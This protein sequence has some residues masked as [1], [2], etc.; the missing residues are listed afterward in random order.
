MLKQLI[1]A[2]IFTCLVAI[3]C[4][5]AVVGYFAFGL[6]VRESIIV[7]IGALA[8]L[9]CLQV[10]LTLNRRLLDLEDELSQTTRRLD[11][12]NTELDHLT[13]HSDALDEGLRNMMNEGDAALK[14]DVR[15]L[16]GITRKL[17]ERTARVEGAFAHSQEQREK[18]RAALETAAENVRNQTAPQAQSASQPAAIPNPDDGLTIEDLAQS[19]AP[20]DEPQV[21]AA[22]AAEYRKR[23]ELPGTTD[24]ARIVRALNTSIDQNRIDVH[25]QAVMTLPARRADSYEA[26]ARFKADDGTLITAAEALPIARREG[27]MAE[28]DLR[29]LARVIAVAGRLAERK[30]STPLSMNLS[31]DMLVDGRR[32]SQFFNLL[33]ANSALTRSIM[34]EIRQDEYAGFGPLEHESLAAIA[35]LGYG[36][37]LDFAVRRDM[38]PRDLSQRGFRSVKMPVDILTAQDEIAGLDIHPQDLA[39]YAR[40]HGLTLIATDVE[41]ESDV[42]GALEYG[43]KHAQGHLFA[44]AKPVRADLLEPVS[45][46]G[47]QTAPLRSL[48]RTG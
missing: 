17:A 22:I 12:T 8:V 7:A 37:T 3:A 20:A 46:L 33:E 47:S 4:S 11:K 39:D 6:S 31:P 36:F 35:S 16:T 24:T 42:V 21:L 38:Q 34:F 32:F 13:S 23:R 30:S 40:R 14:T 19:P 25:L 48:R 10:F 15:A 27:L 44:E 2:I 1:T 43:V 26:L 29:M 45:P 41:R 9:V 5:A 28:L 18:A